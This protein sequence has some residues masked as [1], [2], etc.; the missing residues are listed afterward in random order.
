MDASCWPMLPSPTRPRTWLRG[1]WEASGARVWQSKKAVSDDE[2]EVD[3]EDRG[4]KVAALM[5]QGR[6]RKVEMTNA[7]AK[8]ATASAAARPELQ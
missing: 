4:G 8:S 5:H 3:G 1:L 2:G 7:T 6:C